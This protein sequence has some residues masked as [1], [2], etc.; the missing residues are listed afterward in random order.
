MLQGAQESCGGRPVCSPGAPVLLASALLTFPV[1]RRGMRARHSS[2]SFSLSRPGGKR[3]C[4][5]SSGGQREGRSGQQAPLSSPAKASFPKKEPFEAAVVGPA[6][7]PQ[8]RRAGSGAL[9]HGTRGRFTDGPA[10]PA[11]HAPR[12]H[13]PGP[14]RV[15]YPAVYT[16][17]SSW[18]QT[19]PGLLESDPALVTPSAPT[20]PARGQDGLNPTFLLPCPSV[21][22]LPIAPT[23]GCCRYCYGFIFK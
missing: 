5:C 14:P 12:V 6:G 17:K 7:P 1:H 22:C 8:P 20:R 23:R 11:S 21:P 15:P 16:Q 10:S 19:S 18:R 2:Q 9:P 3:R 4:V 13:T